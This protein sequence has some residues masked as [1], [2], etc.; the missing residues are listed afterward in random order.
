M[1]LPGMNLIIAYNGYPDLYFLYGPET[2]PGK[3][4]M[5]FSWTNMCPPRTNLD[6]EKENYRGNHNEL[7]HWMLGRLGQ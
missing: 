1:I 6:K 5:S 2:V 4:S 3:R 7:C